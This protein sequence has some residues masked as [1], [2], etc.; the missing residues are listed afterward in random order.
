M[1]ALNVSGIEQRLEAIAA[2]KQET[3]R[4]KESLNKQLFTGNIHLLLAGE[5][6][7]NSAWS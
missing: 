6:V 5:T 2:E 4:V 7:A 3:R 1:A